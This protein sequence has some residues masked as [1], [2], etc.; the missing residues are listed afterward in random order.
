MARTLWEIDFYVKP[1]GRCPFDDFYHGLSPPEKVLVD[2]ALKRLQEDW[3]ALD[4]P[5]VGYL[6]DHIRELRAKTHYGQYRILH[7]F[8]ER[9]K[10]II[11][12]GFLKK[13]QRVPDGEIDRAIEYRNDY[14]AQNK[15]G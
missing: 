15:R 13:S 12:Q 5:Y 1:N 6:R 11:L 9:R 14:L 2:N 4:R 3:L 7:F 10:F 8:F